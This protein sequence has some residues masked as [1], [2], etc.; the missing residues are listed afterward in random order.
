MDFRSW[1]IVLVICLSSPVLCENQNPP[2]TSA[3][4]LDPRHRVRFF[5]FPYFFLCK[6]FVLALDKTK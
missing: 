4:Q 5:R 2:S 6:L 3:V 1:L